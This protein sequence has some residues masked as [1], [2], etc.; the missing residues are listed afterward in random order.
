[1]KSF[2]GDQKRFLPDKSVYELYESATIHTVKFHLPTKAK[3]AIGLA[4]VALF[5]IY[6][7]GNNFYHRFVKRDVDHRGNPI[8]ENVDKSPSS[9][10]KS[11]SLEKK[12]DGY[13]SDVLTA[14][15]F[16][17]ALKISKDCVVSGVVR[18]SSGERVM[19]AC[20]DGGF[21]D[22]SDLRWMGG[23][24]YDAVRRQVKLHTGPVIHA[25]ILVR[26]DGGK[27]SAIG[28]SK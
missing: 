10:L 21:Y 5:A 24:D 27:I 12:P 14:A 6:Y 25:G 16:R 18:V 19:I 8:G 26:E 11:S 22:L 3:L 28:D 4:L 15:D 13:S 7:G 1:M 23:Y 20:T 9:A 2:V 17:S